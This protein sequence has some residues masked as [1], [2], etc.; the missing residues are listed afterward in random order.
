MGHHDRFEARI[1]LDWSDKLSASVLLQEAGY[2]ARKLFDARKKVKNYILDETYLEHPP[3]SQKYDYQYVFT[4][5]AGN[6]DEVKHFI[7]SLY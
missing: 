2:V 6:W 4:P 1:M 3:I 7:E 5:K